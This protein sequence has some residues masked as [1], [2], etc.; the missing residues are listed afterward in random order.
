[1]REGGQRLTSILVGVLELL[2]FFV[3]CGCHEV[4]RMLDFAVKCL[5][6]V[7]VL[8]VEDSVL[9]KSFLECSVQSPQVHDIVW[10]NPLGILRGFW[11]F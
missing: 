10:S 5:V 8:L 11:G 4:V 9:G 7:C 1:M 6:R 2:T 3:S